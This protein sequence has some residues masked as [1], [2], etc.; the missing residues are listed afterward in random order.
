MRR[1][2]DRREAGNALAVVGFTHPFMPGHIA[3]GVGLLVA[4][5]GWALLRMSDDDFD[6]APGRPA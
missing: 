2:Q 3:S 6:R 5:A 4:G 1:G